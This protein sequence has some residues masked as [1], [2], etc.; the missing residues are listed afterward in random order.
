MTRITDLSKSEE[1]LLASMH[2]KL[3]YNIG[4]AQRNDV[5]VRFDMDELNRVWHLFGETSGRGQFRLHD[6]SHYDL[7][8]TSLTGECRAFLAT[9]WFED[10][11]IAANLMVDF[12]GVRTYLHGASDYEYR[13]LMA[14]HLLHWELMRDAKFNGL[15]V[16]DWWG[17]SPQDQP[18]HPLVGVSRFKRQFPGEDISYP[19]TYDLVKRPVWYTLYALARRARRNR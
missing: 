12:A 7:M 5:R 3:R 19:G 15:T 6:K 4:L 2:P 17:V 13:T 11:P 9:A 1:E 18:K 8:L 10:Q 14:P 16:Y